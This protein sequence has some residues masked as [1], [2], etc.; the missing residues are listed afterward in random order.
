[1]RLESEIRHR[2]REIRLGFAEQIVRPVV[3]LLLSGS[4]LSFDL[5]PTVF[6]AVR[7]TIIFYHYIFF[8]TIKFLEN[9]IGH[10]E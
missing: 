8:T 9:G 6:I 3:L 5:Q 7:R 1:M 2:S 10:A 4:K